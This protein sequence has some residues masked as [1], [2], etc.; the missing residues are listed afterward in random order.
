MAQR[1]VQTN[2]LQ[3]GALGDVDRNRPG[4]P[5]Y[6]SGC[7]IAENVIPQGGVLTI[8]PGYS[9]MV[10]YTYRSNM[11]PPPDQVY[12]LRNAAASVQ[13]GPD[14]A[15]IPSDAV[16]AGKLSD[17]I[18]A[19][20]AAGTY[21]AKKSGD[22]G[23]GSY[24]DTS[25]TP[26]TGTNTS[27]WQSTDHNSLEGDGKIKYVR[28]F[29][30]TN[31]KTGRDEWGIVC[32]KVTSR[33]DKS[34]GFDLV[35]LAQIR[36]EDSAPTLVLGRGN[37]TVSA[38]NTAKTEG[39]NPFNGSKY[40]IKTSELTAIV[41]VEP[42]IYQMP[43]GWFKDPSNDVTIVGKMSMFSGAPNITEYSYTAANINTAQANSV[44][45]K[46]DNNAPSIVGL[47]DV[48]VLYYGSPAA[49]SVPDDY[50]VGKDAAITVTPGVTTATGG[51]RY[52]FQTTRTIVMG[53][54]RIG[55][56]QYYDSGSVAATNTQDDRNSGIAA[57]GTASGASNIPGTLAT[58]PW[59]LTFDTPVQWYEQTYSGLVVG[60]TSAEYILQ[61]EQLAPT[62]STSGVTSKR[63]S[64]VGTH[65]STNDRVAISAQLNGNI[66]FCTHRGVS[67]MTFSTERQQYLPQ[68]IDTVTAGFGVPMS[69]ASSKKYGVIFVYTN[70]SKIVCINPDTGGI[71]I[72]TDSTKRD[73]GGVEYQIYGLDTIDGEPRVVWVSKTGTLTYKMSGL[74]GYTNSTALIRSSRFGAMTGKNGLVV[75]AYVSLVNAAGGRVRVG[76]G[77]YQAKEFNWVELP[78]ILGQVDPNGYQLQ[79]GETPKLFTGVVKVDLVDT[80]DN[81]S[82][83]K[84]IE[85]QFQPGEVAS[86]VSVSVEMKEI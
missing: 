53:A 83:G 56:A 43:S 2:T 17:K 27:F 52:Y 40:T 63:I 8:A 28:A 55:K 22:N 75:S 82:E 18:T 70:L 24:F 35:G 48:W 36:N 11:M 73:A 79:A 61:N 16:V 21:W 65:L 26:F 69:I 66:L 42:V 37:L 44:T 32:K 25:G 19:A 67:V 58:D 12:Y 76:A 68:L 60:T 84:A 38:K 46:T 77:Q 15:T 49:G 3:A 34:W 47:E 7:D 51:K 54:R 6:A 23:V 59:F 85:L 62:A 74:S 29:K 71:T 30:F 50:V 33:Q 80:A 4:S 5:R 57:T 72:I 13:T 78:Y 64:S 81:P 86:L 20:L 45:V 10:D 1:I 9:P 41:K 14:C 31:A 39:T